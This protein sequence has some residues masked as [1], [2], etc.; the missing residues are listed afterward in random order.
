[1]V[2]FKLKTFRIFPNPP[3]HPQSYRMVFFVNFITGPQRAGPVGPSASSQEARIESE[4]P[5][6]L[7]WYADHL[8]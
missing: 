3:Y 4:I 5:G 1:M 8:S 6:K 2:D 7:T